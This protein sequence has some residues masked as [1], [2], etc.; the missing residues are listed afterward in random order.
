MST[1]KYQHEHLRCLLRK[2]Y[3]NQSP[4]EIDFVVLQL[5]Q[6]LKSSADLIKT[7][8]DSKQKLW[9]ASSSVLITYPDVISRFGEPSLETLAELINDHIKNLATI[10]HV[11]PFLRSTSDGGF[12]VSS[13]DEI[14]PDF[15]NWEHLQK[16]GKTRL[17]MADLILNHISASHPW[18]G[19]FRNAK[20][21]G[22]NY[23]LSPCLREN[24]SNVFR[25][26][27]SSLFTSLNTVNG[28]KKVWTTFSPD[29][30]DLNWSEPLLLVE[31]FKIIV[32]YLRYG[33]R[34]IRLD[35]IGFIWKSPGT[36]CVHLEEAHQI[37]KVLRHQIQKL[38]PEGV[39]VTETNV[40]EEENLSYLKT[41]DEANLAYNF[42]LPPLI[43]ESIISNNSDLLNKWL[44]HW[45]SLP[46]Q[47]LLLNFTAS[48]DGVGLMPL[49]GLISQ[50]RLKNLLIN[51]ELRGGLISHRTMPSGEE[52]PYE[53]NISWWSAMKDSGVNPSNFQLERFL[54]SQLFIMSLQG[55][56]AFYVQALLASE[57]NIESYR[58]TGQR[59]DLNRERFDAND[60]LVSLKDK[61]SSAFK[62][63]KYLKSAMAIRSQL[64]AFHPE[65]PMQCLSPHKKD[66]VILCRGKGK[67]RIWAL[68]N[69]TNTRIDFSLLN[70]LNKSEVSKSN[71]WVDCLNNCSIS[72]TDIEL[73][74]YSVIWLKQSK[75]L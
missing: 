46:E 38:I 22:V 40:P 55:I 67:E 15:G 75:N 13:H 25:P 29:Q 45:P 2:I 23:I 43:L 12:A 24:W 27:N 66:L 47:S 17:L 53:L 71:Q 50:D 32:R 11:L 54:L 8:N 56:P 68:H 7:K 20:K 19:Q 10:V 41:G 58:K 64:I 74:P 39:L 59:R 48:H 35:A 34:W 14:S 63:L 44:E 62:N 52:E 42:P 65:S 61:S 33:V 60:L 72:D 5:M 21:P 30:I 36:E 3:K 18:V 1:L 31:Y 6:I 16:I 37:V 4:A 57:N 28:P 49:K 70:V 26:R 51:C 69:F 9:D 73:K